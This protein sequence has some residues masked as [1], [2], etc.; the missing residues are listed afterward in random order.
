MAC[1]ISS[2]GWCA[3][4]GFVVLYLKDFVVVE[5]VVITKVERVQDNTSDNC[6]L[7]K[8]VIQ[9]ASTCDEGDVLLFPFVFCHTSM[10][11]TTSWF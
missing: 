1:I 9:Y 2:R 10:L 6:L 8:V 5:E 3:L 11:S 7:N 4:P